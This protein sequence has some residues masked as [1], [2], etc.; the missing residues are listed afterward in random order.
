M[1][2][3]KSKNK[4]YRGERDFVLR[5]R[6]RGFGAERM[7]LSGALGSV[8]GVDMGGDVK[9]WSVY[10]DY[11]V[12][13]KWRANGF[14]QIYKWLEPENIDILSLK[15]DHQKPLVVMTEE[16]LAEIMGEAG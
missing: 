12:E 13:C 1:S 14:K 4:G 9:L 11:K 6:G 5:W 3:R 7:P 10:N 8:A 15:A 2:G 16:T